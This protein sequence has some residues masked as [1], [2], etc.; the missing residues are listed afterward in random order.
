MSSAN[1]NTSVAKKNSDSSSPSPTTPSGS[2]RREITCDVGEC[3]FTCV[4][5]DK[6]RRHINEVHG[7]DSLSYSMFKDNI[8]PDKTSTQGPVQQNNVASTPSV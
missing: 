5:K 8:S 6:M 4:R 2:K 1:P 3:K 7:S